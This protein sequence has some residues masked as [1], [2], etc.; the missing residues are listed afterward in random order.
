MT[1]I[2]NVQPSVTSRWPILEIQ[3]SNAK[4]SSRFPLTVTAKTP[5]LVTFVP[6]L[7]SG[8]SLF[9]TVKSIFILKWISEMTV[10]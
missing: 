2:T 7:G 1:F 9:L 3:I 5:F 4:P 6:L 8:S 10:V